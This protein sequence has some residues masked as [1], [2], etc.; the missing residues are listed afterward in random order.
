MFL[1]LFFFPHL[2][3]LHAKDGGIVQLR[4]QHRR[5]TP[6]NVASLAGLFN[7]AL[8]SYCHLVEVPKSYCSKE[9]MAFCLFANQVGKR[10]LIVHSFA[11]LFFNDSEFL[12]HIKTS[13]FTISKQ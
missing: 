3:A 5:N 13:L 7:L 11:P 12:K 6:F 9:H 8:I 4:K 1:F 2:N 10:G